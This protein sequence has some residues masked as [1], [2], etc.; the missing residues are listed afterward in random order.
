MSASGARWV[1]D[2][3]ADPTPGVEAFLDGVR[4][5]RRVRR[6]L[7]SLTAEERRCLAMRSHGRTF[8]EIGEAL[9]MKLHQAAYLTDVAIEKV[10]REIGVAG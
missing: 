4:L 8:R 5:R 7:A 10:Q 1:W 9:G 2:E 6:A 3:A